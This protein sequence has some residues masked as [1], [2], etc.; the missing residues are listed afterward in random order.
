MTALKPSKPNPL[1]Y[2]KWKCSIQTSSQVFM[3]IS[4]HV[5]EHEVGHCLLGFTKMTSHTTVYRTVSTTYLH[6][7]LIAK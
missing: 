6:K 4:L 3:N 5:A 2:K 1:F 7:R